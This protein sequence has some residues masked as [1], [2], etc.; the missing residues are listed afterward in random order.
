MTTS[1]QL[2]EACCQ[3]PHAFPMV[4][5]VLLLQFKNLVMLTYELYKEKKK[6][7]QKS[8]HPSLKRSY[9]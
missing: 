8:L 7:P 9:L 2:S 6:K 4:T 1:P 3:L 5:D